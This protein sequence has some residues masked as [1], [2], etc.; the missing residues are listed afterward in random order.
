MN[1]TGPVVGRPDDDPAMAAF[2]PAPV[3]PRSRTGKVWTVSPALVIFGA[4]GLLLA[5]A[6]LAPAN[7]EVS[8]GRDVPGVVFALIYIH[9]E[10]AR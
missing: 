9:H 10:G 2:S 6:L 4:L 5:G 3:I 8:V 7:D 1:G